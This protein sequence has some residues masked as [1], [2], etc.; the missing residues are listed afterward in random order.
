MEDRSMTREEATTLFK[1]RVNELARLLAEPQ[2]P[3]G[4]L[5]DAIRVRMKELNRLESLF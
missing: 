2:K 4:Y 1:V 5:E 3:Q